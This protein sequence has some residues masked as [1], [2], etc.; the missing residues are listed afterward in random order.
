[1]GNNIGF[2]GMLHA[3]YNAIGVLASALGK[4]AHAAENLGT[5]ADEQTGSFVDEA[6]IERKK[7][8]VKLEAELLELQKSAAAQAQAT[9]TTAH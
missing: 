4:F 8:Q 7:Q 2:F 9:P 5:Y 3:V 6:R 1:M